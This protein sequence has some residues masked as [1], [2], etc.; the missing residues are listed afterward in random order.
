MSAEVR[1]DRLER[2]IDVTLKYQDK[3]VE[4]LNTDFSCRSREVSLLTDVASSVL[5]MQH[6]KKHLRS[7]MK[8]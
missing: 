3:L 6:A 5:P 4:A 1:I 8:A 7:W 2:G